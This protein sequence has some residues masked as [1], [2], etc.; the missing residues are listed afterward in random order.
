MLG[1]MF[2]VLPLL[3]EAMDVQWHG[4]DGELAAIKRHR[5]PTPS[6]EARQSRFRWHLAHHEFSFF[7]PPCCSD[8]TRV[9]V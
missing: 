8:S 3:A 5:P 2:F 1:K 4:S 7:V 9:H 6:R